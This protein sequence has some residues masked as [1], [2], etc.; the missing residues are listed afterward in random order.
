MM[1]KGLLNK[2][3]PI[4]KNQVEIHKQEKIEAYDLDFN[5]VKASEKHVMM[6]AHSVYIPEFIEEKKPK[7]N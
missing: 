6:D 4:L 1:E 7:T 2:I 5:R 3:Q